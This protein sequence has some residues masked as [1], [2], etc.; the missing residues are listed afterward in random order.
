MGDRERLR[1]ALVATGLKLGEAVGY[2]GETLPWVL[3]CREVLLSQP[4]LAEASRQLWRRLSPYRP[5]VVAGMTLSA[6]PLIAGVLYAALDEG[7]ELSGAIVRKEAKSYGRGRLVEGREIRSSDRVVLVDD[8]L[9]GGTTAQACLR[10]LTPTRAP[11]FAIGVLVDFGLASAR[12]SLRRH[13]LAVEALFTTSD[14]GLAAQLPAQVVR[15]RRLSA[16]AAG[17]RGTA[18]TLPAATRQGARVVAD[19]VWFARDADGMLT[20]RSTAT[21]RRLWR[22]SLGDGQTAVLAASK[23]QVV[24]GVHRRSLLGIDVS[25]TFRWATTFSGGAP[26]SLAPLGEQRW[27]ALAS[28]GSLWVLDGDD[29]APLGRHAA[30]AGTLAIEAES[31]NRLRCVAANGRHELLEIVDV[32]R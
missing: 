32:S 25:G 21:G 2:E 5:T 18:P 19:G 24:A 26:I 22:R 17:N 8:L 3:D 4:L 29:G 14:L 10:A 13:G 28:N 16:D 30:P 31:S 15:I 20:C 7:V 9:N 1:R 11:V 12:R 27:A 6:D 23:R